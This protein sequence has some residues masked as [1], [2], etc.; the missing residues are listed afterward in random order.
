VQAGNRFFLV[1]GR[2]KIADFEQRKADCQ[3]AR[4]TLR[5]VGSFD[6]TPDREITSYGRWYR[7]SY[8]VAPS[9][10]VAAHLLFCKNAFFWVPKRK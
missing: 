3:P 10:R 8:G 7:V 6:D 4:V 9:H 2:K 5:G 1:H